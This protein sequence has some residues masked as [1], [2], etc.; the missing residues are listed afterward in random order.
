[1]KILLLIYVW[2]FLSPLMLAVDRNNRIL[3]H[4]AKI[5][6]I[7]FSPLTLV[8]VLFFITITLIL[9]FPDPLMDAVG[10]AYNN[11]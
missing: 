11:P 1:M 6:M 9:L 3:T 10:D 2:S 7:V 4:K 5:W 8:I